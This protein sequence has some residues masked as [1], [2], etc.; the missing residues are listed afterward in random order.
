MFWLQKRIEKRWFASFLL[1]AGS[2][3]VFS[4]CAMRRVGK[5]KNWGSALRAAEATRQ[6]RGW[7][8]GQDS[9]WLAQQRRRKA[10]ELQASLTSARGRAYGLERQLS[11]TRKD[12]V[13]AR[14]TLEGINGLNADQKK[15]VQDI[16]AQLDREK[17]LNARLHTD[18][19]ALQSRTKVASAAQG[20]VS[21]DHILRRATSVDG[22][23]PALPQKTGA[24][25]R[26]GSLSRVPSSLS[27]E[28]GEI[29]RAQQEAHASSSGS[30]A[31]GSQN[32]LMAVPVSELQAS[33]E[34]KT[35]WMW[36][37]IAAL[38]GIGAGS[39]ATYKLM[40]HTAHQED[41]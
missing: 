32:S 7:W 34:K 20:E 11:M 1:L 24:R 29:L 8:S 27:L 2:L 31:P 39:Y 41:R 6:N 3:S 22:H 12:L 5:D 17:S 14:Q 9:P 10:L 26:A 40:H 19:F 28:M 25:P 23:L 13:S 15:A 38:G 21:A 35:L 30:S 36:S 33:S 16:L 37:I 18:L 4:L